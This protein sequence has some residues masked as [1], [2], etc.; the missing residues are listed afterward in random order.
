VGHA[1]S[2]DFRQRL[3]P[4]IVRTYSSGGQYMSTQKRVHVLILSCVVLSLL[5]TACGSSTTISQPTI[6]ATIPSGQTVTLRLEG[7]N[8][9]ATTA[10]GKSPLLQAFEAQHPNIKIQDKFVASV[11]GVKTLTAETAAND[12]PDIAQLPYTSLDYIITSLSAQPIDSIAPKN[13]YDATIQHILPRARLLGVENGHLYGSP[14]TVSTPTLFYNATL[15]KAAGL[16]PAKPPTTWDEVRADAEQIK[17]KTSAAPVFIGQEAT[18]DWL[19]QSLLSSNGGTTLSTD[20][21]HATFNQPNSVAVFQMWQ[22]L[23]KA[24][25]YPK[26]SLADAETAMLNGKLGMFLFTTA[27]LPSLVKAAHGTF[28]LRTSGEPAFGNKPVVP[29]NSGSAL[30]VFSKDPLKQYAAWE[31]LRFAAS[32]SGNTIITSGLGYLPL[33]DDVVANPHY[34]QPYFGKNTLLLPALDQL[35]SLQPR[36]SWPGNNSTQAVTLYINA[37]FA[38]VYEGKN[39]QQTLDAAATRVDSLLQA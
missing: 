19:T 17:A 23:V 21:Q 6:Q 30:F 15:F 31:F 36:V 3:S 11:D 22:G 35:S 37:I 32:Q 13:E 26:L 8:Y 39:A 16:D 14:F 29:V 7:Y 34:L 5:V 28:D 33:R 20:R 4:K 18:T 25:L 1:G 24:G 10:G 27:L 9:G 2:T 12:A 38:V